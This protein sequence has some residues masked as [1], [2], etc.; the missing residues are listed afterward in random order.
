MPVC[1][2]LLPHHSLLS[3]L[4]LFISCSFFL[5]LFVLFSFPP[6]HK[7][8]STF[9]LIYLYKERKRDKPPGYLVGGGTEVA[10]S[11]A[12]WTGCEIGVRSD[13]AGGVG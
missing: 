12:A 6:R 10:W 4:V 7:T 1:I 13:V 2:Y 3:A 11:G 8:V 9:H 5:S